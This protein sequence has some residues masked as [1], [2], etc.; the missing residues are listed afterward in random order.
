M[1]KIVWLVILLYKV[2]L[3]HLALCCRMIALFQGAG[4]SSGIMQHMNWLLMAI[5]VQLCCVFFPF[6]FVFFGKGLH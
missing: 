5:F 4:F 1:H 3:A 2:G 6:L